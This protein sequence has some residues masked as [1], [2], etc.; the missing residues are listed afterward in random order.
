MASINLSISMPVYNAE[1]YLEE[2]IGSIMRQTYQDFELILVDDGSKDKSLEICEEWMKKYPEKIRI[3]RKENNG[4]LLTRK[5]CIQESKYEYIYI[6]DADDHL[7][8][9]DALEQAILRL[10]QTG[11][12]VIFFDNVCDGK[13]NTFP[14]SDGE[15]FEGLDRNKIYDIFVSS[16]LL[17]PMWNK[18]FKKTLVEMDN[19]YSDYE[20]IV[21]G[22][23]LYQSVPIICRAKKFV[24][25]KQPLYYYR[26]EGNSNSIVH[27]FKPQ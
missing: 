6:M 14:F 15:I 19:Y 17:N 12:D 18:I 13:E 26:F 20:D 22:T 5:R 10:S 1:Q 7:Y 21:Y 27:K 8:R 2:S 4:S 16:V 25:L 11:A 9:T 3:V 23:D 24:Y